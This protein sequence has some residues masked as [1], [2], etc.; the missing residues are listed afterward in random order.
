MGEILKLVQRPRAPVD[1][2]P[3]LE[4]LLSDAKAGKLTGIVYAATYETDYAVDI[5]GETK[6][7]P[8]FA[9]GMLAVLDEELARIIRLQA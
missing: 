2:V 5:V 1:L 4:K 3:A 8:T 9:R 6:I 7:Q